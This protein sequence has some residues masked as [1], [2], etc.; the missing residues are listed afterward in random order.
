MLELLFAALLAGLTIATGPFALPDGRGE[1]APAARLIRALVVVVWMYA[2]FAAASA[3]TW[4][5]D[6]PAGLALALGIAVGAAGA[7]LLAAGLLGRRPVAHP[8]FTGLGVLFA[9]AAVGGRSGFALA[10]TGVLALLA[11]WAARREDRVGGVRGGASHALQ[12]DL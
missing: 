11:W 12:T 7:A 8:Q 2:I 1:P 3:G 6:V 9:G 10:L 5:V 4:P